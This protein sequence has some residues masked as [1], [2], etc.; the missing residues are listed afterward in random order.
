MWHP[1]L[2]GLDVGVGDEQADADL[3]SLLGPIAADVGGVE[4]PSRSAST[5]PLASPERLA[6]TPSLLDGLAAA[7]QQQQQ[8]A[9]GGAL[10]AGFV[11]SAAGGSTATAAA[12][13]GQQHMHAAPGR[14]DGLLGA[15]LACLW[16]CA[17]FR[18]LVLTWP[19]I[20]HKADPVVHSLHRAF[21][22]WGAVAATQEPGAAAAAA[23]AVT[24]AA[25]LADT[26]SGQLFGAG[27]A[28][29]PAGGMLAASRTHL[30][31]P[32]RLLPCASGLC[33]PG[34]PL[35]HTCIAP[36]PPPPTEPSRLTLAVECR[37]AGRCWGGAGRHV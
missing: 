33:A 4:P 32:L 34:W 36:W 12:P 37:P 1:P 14:E 13:G 35:L 20:V 18:Q 15:L 21:L 3:A 28:C 2:A 10:F 22:A 5:A 8:P 7:Q 27:E 24:A 26:L 16:H 17:A 11:G 23:A 19:E 9:V 30:S 25:E 6:G 31:Q 29:W